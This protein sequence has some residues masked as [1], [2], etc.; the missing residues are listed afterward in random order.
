MAVKHIV[1]HVEANY[2]LSVKIFDLSPNN[3]HEYDYNTI[4]DQSAV[5]FAR[6]F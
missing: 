4:E 5:V 2:L 3:S 1:F 6:W